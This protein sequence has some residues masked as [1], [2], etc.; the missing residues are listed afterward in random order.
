MKRTTG[1]TK[2]AKVKH[3]QTRRI[4]YR[5][6]RYDLVAD[7]FDATVSAE[8]APEPIFDRVTGPFAGAF[9]EDL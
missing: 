6:R 8:A 9:E 3:G 2:S 7:P 5:P 4:V 1:T